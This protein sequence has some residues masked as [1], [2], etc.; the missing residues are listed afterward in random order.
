[1]RAEQESVSK[2]GGAAH[3]AGESGLPERR[4]ERLLAALDP[5]STVAP[6]AAGVE[7]LVSVEEPVALLDA[8]AETVLALG[9]ACSAGGLEP[10]AVR[11]ELAAWLEALDRRLGPAAPAGGSS[12]RSE[13]ALELDPSGTAEAAL[14]QTIEAELRF[15]IEEEIRAQLAANAAEAAPAGLSLLGRF[16]PA[17]SRSQQ[18]AT[19]E[20]G[21]GVDQRHSQPEAERDGDA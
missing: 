4:L 3:G 9:R 6:A 15:Q 16:R 7:G 14:R 13:A 5:G 17:A 12:A 1:M 21:T 18:P 8:L 10:A 11:R 2:A 20:A 19:G